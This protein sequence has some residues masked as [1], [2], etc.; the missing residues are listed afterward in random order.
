MTCC[1]DMASFLL[2]MGQI[3][4]HRGQNRAYVLGASLGQLVTWGQIVP[5]LLES[6]FENQTAE[7]EFSGLFNFEVSLVFLVFRFCTPLEMM[8]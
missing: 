8:F 3:Q 7:T 4:T 2:S 6:V 1:R 5:K